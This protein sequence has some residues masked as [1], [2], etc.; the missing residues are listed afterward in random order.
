MQKLNRDDMLAIYR[1]AMAEPPAGKSVPPDTLIWYPADICT[2]RGGYDW[3]AALD[4]RDASGVDSRPK[5]SVPVCAAA[6]ENARPVS[7][8]P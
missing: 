8:M 4:T 3:S 2:P 7:T 5:V 6:G 1:L